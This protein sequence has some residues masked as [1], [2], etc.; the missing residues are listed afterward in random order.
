MSTLISGEPMF[1][2]NDHND[3]KIIKDIILS[4]GVKCCRDEL[5]ISYINESLSDF[6]YG[7]ILLSRKAQIGK[8]IVN[9]NDLF[10]LRSFTLFKYSQRYSLIQ[11]KGICSH[12][13]YKGDGLILLNAIYEFAISNK[14]HTW[15]IYSLPRKKL[16]NYYKEF[17]FVV[18]D[19]LYKDGK[20]KVYE[21]V[22]KIEYLS[23]QKIEDDEDDENDEENDDKCILKK[24]K[25]K[26]NNIDNEDNKDNEDNEDNLFNYL[27]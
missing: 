18:L 11:G 6:D 25:N 12:E 8:T 21:M 27:L 23:S 15:R 3:I 16:V 19:L 4:Q 1:F 14:V 7:F 20:K 13:N 22:K 24:F 26:N 9:K 17:G 2:S 10:T 5:D